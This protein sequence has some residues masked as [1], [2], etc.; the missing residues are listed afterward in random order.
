MMTIFFLQKVKIKDVDHFENSY[1]ITLKSKKF[2]F[3][4]FKLVLKLVLELVLN[5]DLELV[6]NLV[7][8]LVL[9]FVLN[10]EF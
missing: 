10:L 7:L 5:L 3:N 4:F 2:E 8:E 6:L 9:K 1:F